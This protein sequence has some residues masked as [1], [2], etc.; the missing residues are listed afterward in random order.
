MIGEI[1]QRDP[2]EPCTNGPLVEREVCEKEWIR[3]RIE[4][5]RDYEI[6]IRFLSLGCVIKVGC[7]EIAFSSA[8]E[9]MIALNEYIENPAKMQPIWQQ[10]CNEEN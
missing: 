2:T 5:L 6:N 4:Y 9:A 1:E 3:P 8:K 7:R 10:A